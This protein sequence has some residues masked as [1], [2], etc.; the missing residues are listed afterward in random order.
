M[1]KFMLILVIIFSLIGCSGPTDPVEPHIYKDRLLGVWNNKDF[2][3][4][5]LILTRDEVILMVNGGVGRHFTYDCTES[6]IMCFNVPYYSIDQI[7]NTTQQYN[8][9]SDDEIEIIVQIYGPY[10]PLF[11]KWTR[12]NNSVD[13][14]QINKLLGYKEKFLGTWI[15]V[16]DTSDRKLEFMDN[17]MWLT[18]EGRTGTRIAWSCTES[19]LFFWQDSYVNFIP[20]GIIYPQEYYFTSDSE[21]NLDYGG[22]HNYWYGSWT[23]ID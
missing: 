3:G 14:R 11:G 9:I 22:F 1:K 4:W 7:L 13:T 18:I 19:V 17:E 2:D 6:E 12:T 8:F 23:K 21:V 20:D 15:N 5:Q 16:N 10:N